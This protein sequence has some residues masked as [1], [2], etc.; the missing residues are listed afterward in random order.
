MGKKQAITN[1]DNC[2]QNA[3]NDALN[4]Q[5]IETYPE[6]IW[7]LKPYINK[8]NWEEMEFP[9]GPNDWIKFEPHNKRIVTNVL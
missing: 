8:Y 6:R 9:V 7:K 5:T 2:F 4:Y 3:L 1:D